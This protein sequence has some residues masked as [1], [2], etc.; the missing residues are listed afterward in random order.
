MKDIK[1]LNLTETEK[2]NGGLDL[3]GLVRGDLAEA[4]SIY[5]NWV[6]ADSSMGSAPSEPKQKHTIGFP[7]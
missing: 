5:T 2:V 7:I 1:K 3:G 4:T 6:L